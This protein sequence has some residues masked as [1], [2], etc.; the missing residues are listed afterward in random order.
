MCGSHE[1]GMEKGVRKVGDGR[2]VVGEDDM[3]LGG[4]MVGLRKGGVYT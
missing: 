3:A 1:R 4:V 2:D